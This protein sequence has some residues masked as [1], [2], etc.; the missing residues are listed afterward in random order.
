MCKIGTNYKIWSI[1]SLCTFYDKWEVKN[2][3]C[4]YG[5]VSTVVS[6]SIIVTNATPLPYLWDSNIRTHD[7]TIKL[8]NFPLANLG[9]VHIYWYLKDLSK[10]LVMF[11]GKS[12]LVK[13][14]RMQ[15]KSN[16]F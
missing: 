7:F 11:L 6:K 2:T 8:K 3:T 15:E 5:W 1:L 12:K 4:T 9:W 16:F 10:L 14:A 13:H